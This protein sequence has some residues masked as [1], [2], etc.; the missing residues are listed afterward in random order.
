MMAESM[1]TLL[2]I[3]AI[4]I[5]GIAC[6]TQGIDG[7][8]MALSIIAVAGLGGYEVYKRVTDDESVV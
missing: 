3:V 2:A 8:I 1:N 7:Q 5:M 6:V 4:A